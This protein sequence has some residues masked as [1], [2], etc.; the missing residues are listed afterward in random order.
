MQLE[1]PNY[2]KV[3]IRDNRKQEEGVIYT[4]GSKKGFLEEQ[5]LDLNL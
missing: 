3:E 2:K 5:S 4:P 1:K